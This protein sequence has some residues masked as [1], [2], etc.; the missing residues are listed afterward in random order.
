L[1]NSPLLTERL[2]A[3][4]HLKLE[5]LQ[6]T[7]SFKIRGAT[8]KMLT[9]TPDEK[10]RGVITISTGN[11]GR[12]VSF[13]AG[14]LGIKATITIPGGTPQNKVDAIKSLGGEIV[15]GGE[16]YD[17]A[18]EHGFRLEKE[19]GLTMVNA[20]DD[21][22]V[23]AGQGTIGLEIL[24]D[25][26]EIDTAIVPMS[27]GGL[28]SGIALALK[29]ASSA[30][31]VVGVSMD[32]APVMYHSLKAGR[33]IT[34]DE[35]ETIA[36]SLRGGLGPDNKH[37][38]RMIQEYVDDFALVSEEEIAAAMAFALEQHHLVVEG[39]GAVGIAA[40]LFDKVR[41]AG[42][43]VAVVLSGSNVDIPLLLKIAQNH[44]SS[45]RTLGLGE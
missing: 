39:G 15:V 35:E 27:G 24:E 19:R 6:E 9:L 40:L 37:S 1:I 23:I 28:I 16:T 12:A 22:F 44:G 45:N 26:P 25:L 4:V 11:H 13:V 14:R 41:E 8:N 30:K 2:G 10:A 21:P 36:D 31:R 7:G 29:S 3:T 20:Y 43:N 33:I 32:R 34:M 42:R 17:E 5:C 18:E 38:F